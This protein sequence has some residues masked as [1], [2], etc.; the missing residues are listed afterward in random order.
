MVV[1]CNCFDIKI[2]LERPN[3]FQKFKKGLNI[4]DIT[5]KRGKLYII[6]EEVSL[7]FCN[8]LHTRLYLLF[9][10]RDLL[11]HKQRIW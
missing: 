8:L 4:S 10:S 5:N 11:S 7:D 6:D 2:L 3:V 9:L 1:G